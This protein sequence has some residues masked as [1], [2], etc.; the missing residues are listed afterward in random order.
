[1]NRRVLILRTSRHRNTQTLDTEYKSLPSI[2]KRI[3]LRNPSKSS[4]TLI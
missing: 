3:L 4:K 2:L 1:M